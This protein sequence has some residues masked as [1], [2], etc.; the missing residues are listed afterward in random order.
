MAAVLAV[1]LTAMGFVVAEQQDET[2]TSHGVASDT[3]RLDVEIGPEGFEPSEITLSAGQPARIVF[4][5]TT[6]ATCAKKIHIPGFGIEAT[7]LPLNE[8]V[9]VDV[10]P[11]EDGTFSV[12]CSMNMI[13]GA[14]LVKSE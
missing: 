2:V 12:A 7:D 11:E 14:I 13:K 3:L 10:R 4:T 9:A 8:P 1:A 6:D 5:R